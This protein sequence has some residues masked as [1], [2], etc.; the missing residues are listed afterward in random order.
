MVNLFGGMV[1]VLGLVAGA[2]VGF[3]GSG[4]APDVE[5]VVDPK[6]RNIPEKPRP[7][8]GVQFEPELLLV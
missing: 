4:V 8:D 1:P 2:E 5:S 3:A 6:T 7:D